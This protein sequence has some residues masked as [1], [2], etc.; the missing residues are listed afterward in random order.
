MP[1]AAAVVVARVLA[2]TPVRALGRAAVL[3]VPLPREDLGIELGRELL[4][5]LVRVVIK[6][7]DAV[8]MIDQLLHGGVGGGNVFG[9]GAVLPE[10]VEIF[11]HSV[12]EGLGQA[13]R[14][15]PAALLDD[16]L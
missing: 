14:K 11:E 7:A 10:R 16:R 2:V 13:H 8:V 9:L 1:V 6:R 5:A 3:L 4:L 12:L 15:S